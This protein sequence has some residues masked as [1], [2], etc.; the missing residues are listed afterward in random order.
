MESIPSV[1]NH[2]MY[3]V[4][5]KC[6]KMFESFYRSNKMSE[7]A[8]L[9]TEKPDFMPPGAPIIHNHEDIAKYLSTSFQSGNTVID[10]TTQQIITESN[11]R[12]TEIGTAKYFN[13]KGEHIVDGKYLVIW[14]GNTENVKLQ[15]DIFNLNK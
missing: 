9:Y 13:S 4:I 15:T 12:F 2:P 11:N 8:L 10:L 14:V 3:N 6:N 1:S 7:V 5:N